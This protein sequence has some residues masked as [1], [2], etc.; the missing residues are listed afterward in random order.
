MYQRTIGP[1]HSTASRGIHHTGYTLL[2]P[3]VGHKAKEKT[4]GR[5]GTGVIFDLLRGKCE[6][7]KKISVE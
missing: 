2:T 1:G 4:N 6:G 3:L 5:Y 7:R